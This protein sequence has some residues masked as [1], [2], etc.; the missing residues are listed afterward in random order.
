MPQYIPDETSLP[1]LTLRGVLLGALITVLFTA[2]NVY[3]GLK[4]GL[5]FAS[6]IPAAVISMAVLRYCRGANVL[7][8]NMVQTQASAAGTLSAIIFILPGLLMVG[9]WQGFPFWQTAAICAIGGILGV[10]YTIPLRRVMV[11]Q[12]SLPYPEGV[13]AAEILDVGSR[14]AAEDPSPTDERSAPQAASGSEPGARE[15][16]LGGLVAA[17]F[18]LCSGGFRVL[19][20]SISVWFSVGRSA[21]QL[22]TG[23]SLALV[24]AGYLVGIVGGMA[25]LIG[26]LLAWGVAVPWLTAIAPDQGES[27]KALAMA[28]WSSDVR[29]IG[30]GT[31]GIAAVWTLISLFGPMVTG[32]RASLGAMRNDAGRKAPGR[33]EQDLSPRIILALLGVLLVALIAV[34]ADFLG[35]AAPAMAA[36]PFWTLVGGC[37]LFAFAFGFLIA[38]ACG[39][40]AGLVGSSSSPISGIGIMAVI[41]VSLLILAFTGVSDALSQLEGSVAAKLPTALALFTTS[42]VVAV[43]AISND[44]LQDL[45]T[46]WLLGATPRRQQIALIIG[47]IVG[48]LVIPPVLSLLYHAYGFT[49]ALPSPDMD[50]NQALGAPQA[51]LMTAIV[52][53]IFSHDLNWPMVL[54]GVALGVGL[55]VIDELLRRRGGVARLPVL[56]VGIGIYLPPS[57]NM[58][59]VIGAVLSWFIDRQ[60]KR[61]AARQGEVFESVAEQPRRRG[62][63]LASGLIVGE[64]LMGV[65]MAGIIGATGE[66]APLALVGDGFESVAQWLGLIVFVLLGLAFYRRILR[67][68]G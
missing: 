46:G 4:V 58:P 1:E 13:A 53:G 7:E 57:I 61:R 36:L 37:V 9:Y 48:A 2:S 31:I 40:M 64:S 24:G 38:A 11:V 52:Q 34:F 51:T 17:L 8:N 45:K 66:S 5:T 60:L 27:L 28:R 23:F 26:T 65:L 67:T 68:G 50:P 15:I 56:A 22:S 43:A 21:F 41:L 62:V 44:N 59:L 54:T 18:S 47:C 42:V 3:L 35:D 49:G 14:H 29:F 10:L 33:T 6:S 25:I 20:E 19:A 39:Y 16:A 55:I 63:L 32:I 12:S 30:A